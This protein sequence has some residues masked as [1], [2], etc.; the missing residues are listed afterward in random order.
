MKIKA[1]PWNFEIPIEEFAILLET[2][3]AENPNFEVSRVVQTDKGL[4]V[5]YIQKPEAP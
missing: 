1:F 3:F 2:W 4:L 5:F